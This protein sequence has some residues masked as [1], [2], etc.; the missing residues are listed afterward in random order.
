MPQAEFHPVTGKRKTR[1]KKL[2]FRHLHS[3]SIAG[4]AGRITGF[5]FIR[6]F[7]ARLYLIVTIS[8]RQVKGNLRP[9]ETRKKGGPRRAGWTDAARYREEADEETAEPEDAAAMALPMLS[10]ERTASVLSW[11]FRI[12][13]TTRRFFALFSAVSLFATGRNSP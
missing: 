3:G 8:G 7:T 2:S 11:G 9:S 12:V 13:M 10:A 5:R 6:G 1:F 4:D